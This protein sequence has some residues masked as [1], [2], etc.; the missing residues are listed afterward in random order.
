M[1]ILVTWDNDEKTIIRHMYKGEW[2]LDE[3]I[4]ASNQTYTMIDEVNDPVHLLVTVTDGVSPISDMMIAARD[5]RTKRHDRQGRVVVIGASSFM[6][7][8]TRVIGA[9]R[10][11]ARAVKFVK[12]EAEAYK[13]FNNA[14]ATNGRH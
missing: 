9:I 2:T 11:A 6:I 1:A 8:L 5:D 4:E 13:I 3:Y 14:K 7:L 10:P 12:T